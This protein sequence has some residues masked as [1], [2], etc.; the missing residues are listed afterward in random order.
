MR[1]VPPSAP[2]FIVFNPGSGHG[3]ADQAQASIRAACAAAG[4]AVELLV[5]SP[6]HGVLARAREA[7]Q[8]AQAEGGV[9][10]AAGGDGTLNAVAQVVLGSGCVFGVLPQGTFNYFGRAHG[11]PADLS[12]A[13]Q[14]LLHEPARPVQ[15]GLVNERVFLVNA[16]LGLYPKLLEDRE[17]WKAQFGRSRWV[18]IG[19]GLFTFLRGRR[20][21][22]LHIEVEGAAREVRTATVF[23][24]NNALQME[25]LGLPL[26]DAI[27]GGRLGAVMLKPVGRLAMAWLLLRGAFG[28]LG[29]AD[30]VLTQACTQLTVNR[31]RA[32]GP[33]R[34]K[35]ATDG[36]VQRMPLPLRFC[37]AP[38]P[39]WLI[40]P[41]APAPERS[42]P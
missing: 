34:L 41:A 36:E 23:V 26:A 24:G 2:L 37:V 27:D 28:R 35:V 40:K 19:A 21:L 22:R 18:A 9:V 3:D 17:G 25:Q 15:V 7:V 4:R 10:V 16:S 38:E 11:I 8:R 6:L 42:A 31:R 14:V 5:V 12:E 32:F 13:L 20:S 29:D 33:R 30:Q 1:S 39:L